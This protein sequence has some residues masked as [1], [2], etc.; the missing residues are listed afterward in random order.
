MHI[1]SKKL[2]TEPAAVMPHF[3][4]GEVRPA[5]RHPTLL[6]Y[7]S[8]IYIK[9]SKEKLTAEP[10]A[11]MPHFPFRRVCRYFLE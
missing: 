10:A 8:K 9:N 5:S 3:S 4:S 7:Y 11:V 6:R 1:L 2:V